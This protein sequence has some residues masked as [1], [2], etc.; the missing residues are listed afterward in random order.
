MTCLCQ[1]NSTIQSRVGGKSHHT[2]RLQAYDMM[3][4]LSNRGLLHATWQIRSSTPCVGSRST[5]NSC[6]RHALA[7]ITRTTTP[8]RLI[9]MGHHPDGSPC[10]TEQTTG[11]CY[12]HASQYS[13]DKPGSCKLRRQEQPHKTA[14]SQ[15]PL[16]ITVSMHDAPALVRN[17]HT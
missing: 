9:L 13:C 17:K 3:R 10:S 7:G 11:S 4:L 1:P 6:S 5:N 2:A 16:T 12:W 8:R 14:C 15:Q